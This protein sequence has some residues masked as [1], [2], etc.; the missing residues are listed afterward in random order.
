MREG[1]TRILKSALYIW[2]RDMLLWF[3]GA[4]FLVVISVEPMVY[5]GLHALSMQGLVPHVE[6]GGKLVTY[7]T[8]VTIGVTVSNAYLSGTHAGFQ[9]FLDNLIG[10]SELLLASPL[11]RYELVLGRLLSALSKTLLMALSA[12]LM[13]ILIGA[14]LTLSP[15]SLLSSLFTLCLCSLSFG[16]LGIILCSKIKSSH[17]YNI[18]MNTI[19]LPAMFSSSA[20]Y[21]KEAL[22][23]V[24][25]LV[26][27]LNPLSYTADSL[28]DVLIVGRFVPNAPNFLPL[29][30]FSL[31]ALLLAIWLYS[32]ILTR[33]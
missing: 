18:V 30:F 21:P 20:F 25:G 19:Q 23:Y 26:A 5:L 4:F 31:I 2:Q 1:A 24:I 6:Y 16:A 22:P 14:Q 9:I 11:K 3:R 12:L 33:A 32:R 15:I 13:G 10:T 7:V 29:A 28:R 17:T 27:S 8:F